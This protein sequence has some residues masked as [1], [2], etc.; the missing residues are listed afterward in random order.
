MYTLGVYLQEERLTMIVFP[1]PGSS[2]NIPPPPILDLV[3]SSGNLLIIN[4]DG[5]IQANLC[6][7]NGIVMRTNVGLE[8]SGGQS[9]SWS[10]VATDWA[11]EE[12]DAGGR[13]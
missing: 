3:Y 7:F 13:I 4:E 1:A 6:A 5:L 10:I 9:S 12:N 11:E 8:V 2:A